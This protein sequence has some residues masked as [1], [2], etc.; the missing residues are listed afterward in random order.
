MKMTTLPTLIYKFNS[1]SIRMSTHFF[2]EKE[3]KIPY[4]KFYYSAIVVK[5]VWYC[6]KNLIDQ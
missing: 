1:I 3:K 5:I 2:T 4:L 6:K